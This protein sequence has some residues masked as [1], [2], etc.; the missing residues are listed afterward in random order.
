VIVQYAAFAAAVILVSM[1]D[2]QL[3]LA[4]GLPFG[5]AA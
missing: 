1:V 4:A 3:L 2:F 5:R